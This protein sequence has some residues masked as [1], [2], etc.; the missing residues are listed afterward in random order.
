[1]L[2]LSQT[3]YFDNEEMVTSRGPLPEKC[4]SYVDRLEKGL[5]ISE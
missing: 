3:G 4:N 2:V 5:E 1:M